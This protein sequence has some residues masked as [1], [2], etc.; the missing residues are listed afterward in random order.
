MYIINLDDES[1]KGTHFVAL[2]IDRNFAGYFDSFGIEYIP[3]EI[4]N[5]IKDKSIIHNIFRMQ[6]N[7]SIVC[8]FYC[9]AFIEY[10]LAGKTLLHYADLLFPNDNVKRIIK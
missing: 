8:G 1:C 10:M 7:E 4:L 6:N 5:K 9:V 3:Q 2:F